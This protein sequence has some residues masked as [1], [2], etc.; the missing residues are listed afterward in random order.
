M[1]PEEYK[2]LRLIRRRQN[3]DYSGR[4]DMEF[5]EIKVEEPRNSIPVS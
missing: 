4:I 3:V 5:E 1:C 2:R